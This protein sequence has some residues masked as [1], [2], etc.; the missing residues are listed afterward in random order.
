MQV[1]VSDSARHLRREYICR[2]SMHML[3]HT[4]LP[5]DFLEYDVEVVRCGLLPWGAYVMR[6]KDSMFE[7]ERRWTSSLH[8][9]E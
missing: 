5:N 4:W 3:L 2:E 7:D 1:N 8:R 9:H 6:E